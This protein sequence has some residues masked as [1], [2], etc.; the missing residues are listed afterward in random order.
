MRQTA[1]A[2]QQAE[3]DRIDATRRIDGQALTARLA[4]Q[5]KAMMVAYAPEVFGPSPKK[6]YGIAF[7]TTPIGQLLE[8]A[9]ALGVTSVIV[10]VIYFALSAI[11]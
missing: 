11:H 4:E 3:F 10:A 2:E 6:T 1:T 5:R 7:P 9:Y 8:V